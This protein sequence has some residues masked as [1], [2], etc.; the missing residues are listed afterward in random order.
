MSTK[1]NNE[2]APGWIGGF[3]ESNPEFAYPDPNISSIRVTR[4]LDNIDKL[5][6]QQ[7]VEWPEF[8]WQSI[9][10]DESSRCFQMFAHDISR[11]GYD[12]YG[13]SWSIICPQQGFCI[14]DFVCINVEV[15]VTG[16]RGWVDETNKTMFAQ[17]G[18]EGVIWLSP[19]SQDSWWVKELWKKFSEA[20]L[21]FPISKADA[22]RVRTSKVGDPE[23]P[24]FDLRSGQTTLFEAPAF[25][26]HKDEAWDVSNLSVQIG[27]PIK[28]GHDVVD[29]FNQKFLDIFNLGSG[30]LLKEGNVLTWDVW[31]TAPG[32]VN[33][34][35][36]ASHAE[37]WRKAIDADHGPQSGPV[38]YA[39]G[40]LFSPVEN[41]KEEF[42]LWLEEEFKELLKDL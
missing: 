42:E 3:A 1:S 13:R 29:T 15:S 37:K 21:P 22:I 4:N 14:A 28:T 12:D 5:Q 40:S 27:G 33:Q 2:P 6:R 38:R 35:E 26:Q 32:I 9:P 36:W 39:D 17:M 41:I 16:Q 25:T 18:V 34:K 19:S 10:G 30:N 8:S 23:E 7:D 24:L 11:L 31:F 20:S